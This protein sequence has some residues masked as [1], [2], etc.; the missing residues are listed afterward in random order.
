MAIHWEGGSDDPESET[1]PLVSY[2]KIFWIFSWKKR[3]IVEFKIGQD[4]LVVTS[5]T[6]VPIWTWIISKLVDCDIAPN[7][8]GFIII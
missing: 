3:S 5:V 8:K 4:R 6:V 1:W 2:K 7:P